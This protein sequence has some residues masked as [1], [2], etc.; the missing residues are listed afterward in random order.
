MFTKRTI[1]AKK[2][3]THVDTA[4]EALAVSISEKAKIDMEFMTS[5]TDKTEQELF[6]DLNGIIF[7]NPLYDSR[8]RTV[9][10]QIPYG[11]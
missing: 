3:I 1:G 6:D 9:F 2:E 5:L 11:R 8:K 4:S 10:S 7:R